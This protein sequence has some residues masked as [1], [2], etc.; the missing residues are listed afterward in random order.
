MREE[1]ARRRRAELAEAIGLGA[2]GLLVAS[3][4]AGL[5]AWV[6]W[7]KGCL[8]NERRNVARKAFGTQNTTSIYDVVHDRGVHKMHRVGTFTARSYNSAGFAN[9][10]GHGAMTGSLAVWLNSEK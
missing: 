8:T 5:V 9:I 4:V 7:L 6:A 10:G 1:L 2:A 3:M